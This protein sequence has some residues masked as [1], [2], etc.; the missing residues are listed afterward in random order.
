[1]RSEAS[2][3]LDVEVQE[4]ARPL[5]LIAAHRQ[6]L[7]QLLQAAE[8]APLQPGGDGGARQMQLRRDLLRVSRYS[9]RRLSIMS[10]HGSAV[11]LAT[12]T[13]REERF[14]SPAAPF[15]LEA[16]Q[17][18]ARRPLAH[19]EARCHIG[20]G[21]PLLNDAPHHLHSTK[22]RHPGILMRVVHPC[23]PQ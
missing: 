14:S 11:R 6:R 23:G 10:I 19:P 9:R 12:D 22:R 13:G 7:L 3:L 15:R 4:L 2:E 18:L 5:T 1:M 8:P 16:G 17:P 21:T 20:D